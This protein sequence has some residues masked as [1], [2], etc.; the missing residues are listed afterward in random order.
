MGKILTYLGVEESSQTRDVLDAERLLEGMQTLYATAP[1]GNK[2]D[3]FSVP[4]AE[5]TKVFIEKV[6]GI[7]PQEKPQ[8]KPVEKLGFDVGDRFY[9]LLEVRIKFIKLK[10]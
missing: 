4:L 3:S 6:K 7:K 9:K 2:R 1:Q 10:A 5:M 8:E